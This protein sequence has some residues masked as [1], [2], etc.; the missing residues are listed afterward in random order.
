MN[1]FLS[2]KN[3]SYT[4]L[5]K[6]TDIGFKFL[7]L[8]LLM[9]LGNDYVV[10]YTYFISL[11][12]IL[13]VIIDF[14]TSRKNIRNFDD[15]GKLTLNIYC[16]LISLISFFLISFFLKIKFYDNLFL[17]FCIV[18]GL[19]NAW[20]STLIK[21]FEFV[22]KNKDYYRT[23]ILVTCITYPIIIT[24]IFLTKNLK[25][26]YF[27]LLISSFI[28]LLKMFLKTKKIIKFSF[29]LISFFSGLPFLL[30]SIASMAFSQVNIIILNQFSTPYLISNFVIAQRLIELSLTFSNSFISSEIGSF[31]KSKAKIL[32]IRRKAFYYWVVLFILLLPITFLIKYFKSNYDILFYVFLSFIPFGFI[33]SISPTYSIVMDYSKYYYLRTVAI[34]VVLSLNVFLSSYV[35]NRSNSLYDFIFF[36]DFLLIILFTFYII[37][38]KKLKI[39]ENYHS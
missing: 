21:Y 35:Y 5:S 3:F 11:S 14:G 33:K 31:F 38:F 26:A 32:P 18:L 8:L 1:F 16:L 29:N 36:I 12:A 24:V 9:Y 23:Q 6:L 27:L 13:S 34:G 39:Y 7:I 22:N 25:I 10:E 2:N 19:I 4:V 37:S 28:L 15:S 30:N 20:K 17:L